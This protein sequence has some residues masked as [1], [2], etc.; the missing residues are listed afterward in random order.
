M[1]KKGV[2]IAWVVLACQ[3]VP[4]HAENGTEA[5]VRATVNALLGEDAVRSVAPAPLAGL[6]EVVLKSGEL[7]Y[8]NEQVSHIVVG[9]II[10][11]KT[12]ENLTEKRQEALAKIDFSTLPL[13]NAIVIKSGDGSRIFASFEDPNC[14]FCKRLAKDLQQVPNIT[15]YL[16][17]YPILG[18]DSTEKAQRILCSANPAETWRAWM[19]DGKAPPAPPANCDTSVIERNLQLGQKLGIGGTPTLFLKDGSRIGGYL[20]A[21]KLEE[22]LRA[23]R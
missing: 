14:G 9:S 2:A 16:F 8:T 15:Q 18:A 4:L 22:R 20:P 23:V 5:K 13:K 17:L 19:V 7:V 3:S 11:A 12:R 1:M 10:D 6:Y 21:A